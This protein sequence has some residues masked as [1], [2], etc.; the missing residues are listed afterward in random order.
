MKT[1]EQ[2]IDELRNDSRIT[3]DDEM[4]LHDVAEYRT[5]DDIDEL[6]CE[7]KNF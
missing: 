5:T 2:I 4:F 3:E 7:V 1:T 6:V